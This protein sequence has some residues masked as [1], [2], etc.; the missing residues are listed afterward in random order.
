MIISI[1]GLLTAV[2]IALGRQISVFTRFKPGLWFFPHFERKRLIFTITAITL[3]SIGYL[4]E[5]SDTT[6]RFAIIASLL[7]GFSFFFDMRRF[8]PELGTLEHTKASAVN[9]HASTL[10]IGT[11]QTSPP[12]AYP[13]EEL[14]IPRHIINDTVGDTPLLVSYCAL[15]RSGIILDPVVK[16]RRL[17]FAVAG[18]WRR[19]MIMV[20]NE[21]ASLW[22]QATGEC[23]RGPYKGTQLRMIASVQTSWD[24]WLQNHADTLFGSEPPGIPKAPFQ[25]SFLHWLLGLVTNHV[26]IPGYSKRLHEVPPREPVYGIQIGTTSKAYPLSTLQKLPENSLTDQIGEREIRL[27]FDPDSHLVQAR[28]TTTNTEIPVEQHW[29]LGW[30]EFHPDTTVYHG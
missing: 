19:N 26:T 2:I 16:G 30:V 18:V 13:L 29:W 4:V 8:F 1:L 5:P 7:C 3:V 22:Q 24:A 20:D 17:S 27:Q 6:I 23:I 28:D 12:I 21:T 11:T 15:C 9:L 10:I 25:H 14:V